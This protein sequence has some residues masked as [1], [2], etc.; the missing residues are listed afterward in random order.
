MVQLFQYVD[1][2]VLKPIR[3]AQSCYRQMFDC[4]LTFPIAIP[5]LIDLAE[6]AAAEAKETVV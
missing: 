6:V 2:P 1:F 5:P 3:P 4:N